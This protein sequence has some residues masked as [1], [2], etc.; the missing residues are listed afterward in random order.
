MK[1]STLASI[2]LTSNKVGVYYMISSLDEM[3]DGDRIENEKYIK[4][5]PNKGLHAFDAIEINGNEQNL[6]SSSPLLVKRESRS[7]E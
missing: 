2:S 5:N 4:Y 3:Y 7:H 1:K 6:L